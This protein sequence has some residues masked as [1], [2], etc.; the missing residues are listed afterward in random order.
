[1]GISYH[2][3]AFVDDADAHVSIRAKALNYGLG[4]FGGI[5]AYWSDKRSELFVFRLGDHA[6]RLVD[7][8]RILGL[9]APATADEIAALVV[10]LLRR[11]GARSDHYIR[12]LVFV[13]SDELSPTLSDV[14]VSLSIYCLPMGRYFGHGAIHAGVSSWRRVADNAI[15]ARAKPTAAYLNSALAR[16]EAKQGG[17]DEAILLTE[18]GTVSEGSAEHLFICRKGQLAT[19]PSTEDNLDGI[20]RATLI[21]LA[22]APE[23]G[24]ATVERVISRTELYTADEVFLC[25][26]GAELTPVTRIDHRPIGSGKVGPITHALSAIFSATVRGERP[27]YEAWLTPVWRGGA[28][29]ASPAPS[30]GGAQGMAGKGARGVESARG[31]KRTAPAR[32]DDRLVKQR[33][34][35]SRA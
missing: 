14:P 33:R 23:V 13:D 19:P 28:G 7:S 30:T 17:F 1:M 34:S 8:A 3:S 31:A 15:P 21:E 26:T 24:V 4:C 2:R 32:R 9:T 11:N 35:S 16:A 5:R 29:A 27:E 18:R 20:T 22:R 12:P 6:R 25:G 10:E